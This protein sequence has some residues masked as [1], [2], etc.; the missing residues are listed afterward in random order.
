AEYLAMAPN[1]D[2]AH[3]IN[4]LTGEVMG[5]ESRNVLVEAARIVRGD[6]KDIA[7]LSA[8]DMDALIFPGGFGAAKNLSSYAFDG[9]NC[10][11]DTEVERLVNEIIAARK[12]LGAI[13][14]APAMLARILES[15]EINSMVT[16][17]SDPQTGG[18]IE[19]MGTTHMECPV[20][21]HITD[22]QN[23]II[24]TPAYMLAEKIGETWEGIGGLVHEVLGLIES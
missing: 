18:D 12:P 17:G 13:C 5:D 21:G 16:I 11:V 20:R 6:I 3:V 10:S 7:T 2:Q 4:H 1:I 24:T 9:P 23:K 15:T 19:K 14:I 8:G 22:K